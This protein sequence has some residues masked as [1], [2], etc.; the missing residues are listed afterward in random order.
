M[1]IGHSDM[2]RAALMLLTME[3]LTM[4]ALGIIANTMFMGGPD[5]SRP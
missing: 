3:T 5:N 2:A 4:A 1:G